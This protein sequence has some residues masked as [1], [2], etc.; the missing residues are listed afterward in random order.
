LRQGLII[1]VIIGCV[2]ISAASQP[3][4]AF[5]PA[6][7]QLFALYV[8]GVGTLGFSALAYYV[9]KNSPAQQAK[10]YPENLGMG[11]WYLAAYS[12]F[13]YLPSQDWNFYTQAGYTVPGDSR[14]LGR[15]AQGVHYDPGVVGGVKFGR[16]FDTVPWL[17]IE[18]ETNFTRHA[19]PEQSVRISPAPPA[20][21][22]ITSDYFDIWALQINLLAR[23]GFLKDKEVNFAR[24]QPYIGIGPG[25][26]VVYARYD[27]G[28]NFA[29]E[30]LT[31]IR[32]MFNANLALFF[33]YKFSYQIQVDIK[34]YGA[35]GFPP[36]ETTAFHVDI[37]NHRFVIGVSY[38]FKN[39]F[40]N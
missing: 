26:E 24:L 2:V 39:L 31:G 15:T 1:L 8:S 13:S 9:Y 14:L 33:E 6:K 37:P 19:I 5:G 16:Y 11:E 25:F 21:L 22:R 3:A 40:A 34:S 27:S 29:F 4:L 36:F 10:G 18:M 7:D 23:Y 35:K 38:H 17:G 32:Y 30:A 28:K 20:S 12:G